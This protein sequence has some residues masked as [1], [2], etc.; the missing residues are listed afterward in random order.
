[1][2]Q[3]ITVGMV[4]WIGG[5]IL[6]FVGVLTVIFVILSVIADGFKH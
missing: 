1:M 2:D 5:G 6:L 3:A 4:L